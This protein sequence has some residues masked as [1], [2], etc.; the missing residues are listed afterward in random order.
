MR[1]KIITIGNSRGVRIPKPLLEATGL[2]GDVE[3]ISHK[4]QIV[5]GPAQNVR[6]GWDAAFAA[7]ALKG[8]DQL[9]DGDTR[10]STRWDSEEW[11]W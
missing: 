2:T 1:S 8:D 6:E 11:Q 10:L 4:N 7:M 9:L 3:L 5:I